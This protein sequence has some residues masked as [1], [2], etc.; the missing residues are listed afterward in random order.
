MLSLMLTSCATTQ[1]YVVR[2]AEKEAA[3]ENAMSTD[4]P[5]SAAG[6]QRAVALKDALK[7]KKISAIYSTPTHRTT[8]T[9]RPLSNETGVAIQIYNP[10]DARF[11]PQLRKHKGTPVLV[12]G[13]S[14]TVDDI[15]NGLAGKQLLQDLPDNQ[16]G[17]LFLLKIRGNK[18]ELEKKRFGN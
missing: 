3:T 2:H 11:L 8:G 1:F 4:V 16:Y 17:D 7:D 9:A 13:H 6:A 15:V 14:N 5:L 10:S 12:V 18:A